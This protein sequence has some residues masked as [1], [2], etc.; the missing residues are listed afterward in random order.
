[1]RII[2]LS[3]QNTIIQLYFIERKEIINMVKLELVLCLKMDRKLLGGSRDLS[4]FFSFFV[5][6]GLVI[7]VFSAN[8]TTKRK[9]NFFLS[10][11]RDFQW[12]CVPNRYRYVEPVSFEKNK[13]IKI[14][15]IKF[16]VFHSLFFKLFLILVVS[17]IL[18]FK[19]YI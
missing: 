14:H 8:F 11:F 13:I 6:W 19:K 12:I 2:T 15:H 4:S 3:L 7:S 5:N 1:M 9:T 10:F 16:L 18:Y 17:T